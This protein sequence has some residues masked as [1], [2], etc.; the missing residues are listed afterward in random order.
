MADQQ[1]QR[2]TVIVEGERRSSYGWIVALVVIILLVLA[3]FMFGGMELFN[4]GAGTDTI[5]IDAPDNV[6][7]TPTN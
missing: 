4:G 6:Q 5:N 1:P 7:V 2:E 3:F